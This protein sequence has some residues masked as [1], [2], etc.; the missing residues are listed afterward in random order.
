MLFEVERSDI[1]RIANRHIL[2]R[3]SHERAATV[4]AYGTF[5]VTL[6]T[7]FVA[8]AGGLSSLRS[9]TAG[10]VLGLTAAALGALAT[11]LQYGRDKKLE[12]QHKRAADEYRRSYEN[13]RS[14]LAQC[15]R[16]GCPPSELCRESSDALN[17]IQA[18]S[19]RVWHWPMAR[20]AANK[21][22]GNLKGDLE[23]D[24]H[25]N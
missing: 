21:E 11:A 13:F 2:H 17:T 16:D 7:A 12:E 10:L 19:P 18:N 14:G 8:A 20:R 1:L 4:W 25:A 23:K 9:S 6:L 5:W 3:I 22:V 15:L 24:L